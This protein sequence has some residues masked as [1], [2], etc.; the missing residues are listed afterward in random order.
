MSNLFLPAS[1]EG[2]WKTRCI[3]ATD[4][5]KTEI[6][7][8]VLAILGLQHGI[9]PPRFGKNASVDKNGVL[10]TNVQ[11]QNFKIYLNQPMRHIQEVIDNLRGL[12]DHLKLSDEDRTALFGEFKKWILL[13]ARANQTNEERGLQK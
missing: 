8:F 4:G 1:M 7:C 12:A 2:N 10:H 5:N 13:D 11:D 6:G 9:T 3:K